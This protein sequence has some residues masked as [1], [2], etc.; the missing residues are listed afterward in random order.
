MF[1]LEAPRPCSRGEAGLRMSANFVND[2]E[3][4][5]VAEAIVLRV[6]V[7]V[8]V[9]L[10]A[11]GADAILLR[12]ICRV[13]ARLVAVDSDAILLRGRGLPQLRSARR[14]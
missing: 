5:A 4:H 2:F 9:Q 13:L 1:L 8:L 14:G 12:R 3:G 7:R 6:R 11:I 10:V